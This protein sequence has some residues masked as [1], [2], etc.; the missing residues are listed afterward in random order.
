MFG[1][2]HEQR[3]FDPQTMENRLD[4]TATYLH[5]LRQRHGASSEFGHI[6]EADIVMAITHL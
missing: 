4:N 6:S 2:C 5:H 3:V 1:S